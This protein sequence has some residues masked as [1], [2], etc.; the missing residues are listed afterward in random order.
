MMMI[1]EFNGILELADQDRNCRGEK[2][3]ECVLQAVS[4]ACPKWCEFFCPF[5][6]Y[7]LGPGY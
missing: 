1:R 5:W 6:S 3:E 7:D 4:K 2:I